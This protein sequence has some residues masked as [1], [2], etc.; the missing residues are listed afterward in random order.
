VEN[1]ARSPDI[2]S[3][4]LSP[5]GKFMGYLF[6]HKG[7]T[8]VS[9]LDLA[10][11]KA[12]YFN[13]GRS[14]IGTNLQMADF[15]W[16]SNERVVVQT[17]AWGQGY[18]G[19]AAV[20]RTSDGW[21]G[22]T[23]VPRWES[24]KSSSDLLKA[25]EIVYAS[26]QDPKRVLLLDR[27]TSSGEQLL[28]PDVLAMNTLTGDYQPL[29]KNRGKVIHWLADWEGEVRFGLFWEGKSS[30]LT[31]R[32]TPT[33]PWQN[34][35]NLGAEGAFVGLD[36][37]GQTIH[38]AQAGQK[39]RW[40]I[41]PYDLKKKQIGEALFEHDD[42]DIIPPDYRPHYAGVSLAAAVYSPK[43]RV[44]LGV[45]Y[46]TE[47]PRQYWFDSAM[48]NLQQQIDAL[49]PDLTN[50][51]VSMDHDENRLLVLSW[52]DREPG[53]YTLVD[54]ASQKIRLIGQRMPWIKPEQMA[55]MF[56]I[57]CPARDGLLLHGYLTLPPDR[58]REN[59]PLVMLVHGGPWVRDVWGFDP[60]VQFLANRDYAVLQINYRGS[61]GYGLDFST[62]GNG[63]I[64]GVIQDDIT[65]AVRWAV[66]QGIADAKRVAIMGAS[67][68]GFSTLFAL[69]KT[70]ELY[71][72]GI[73]I[74]GVTDWPEL[75]K[76]R[77]KH[78][79]KVSYAYW[80]KR[81]GNMQDEKVIQ[82]LTEASPVNFSGQIKAPLL[83]V[84]GA[85]DNVVPITQTKRLVA[86]LKEQRHKPET[87]YL[88]ALGHA[89][90]EGEQGVEFYT[91]L[92][93]FLAAN[94]GAK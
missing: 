28:Y 82:Q 26:G 2:S 15:V 69:A 18:A 44:L 1:F 94:L 47:G 35:P 68:G 25:Y 73:D 57:T 48:D 60:L 34:L 53:F 81:V 10:T 36:R 90:P 29:V 45:R 16:V 6:T 87:L 62:K 54:L 5:D 20:N 63:Q 50:L 59:L 66:R 75:R 39:R 22:L 38:V 72:C 37:T 76:N 7:K 33:A 4:K 24:I 84:H 56:P 78:E 67:Y 17:T 77:D 21:L 23:G 74:A 89:I 83:I 27:K 14:V 42:Y 86:L 71:R 85:E 31:Y 3:A 55:Q 40:A 61:T 30:R 13:P 88:S 52:S 80:E 11:G 41:F 46:V 8:E 65:D 9:F 49:H 32:E 43:A 93:A 51:I 12:R 19:L 70:P 79:Y 92:E 64:G 58:G 91:K